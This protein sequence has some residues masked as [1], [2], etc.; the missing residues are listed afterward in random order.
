MNYRTKPLIHYLDNAAAAQPTPGGGSVA[1]VAGALAS[2][3]ASMAAGFTKGKE[4]FKD[5]QP[6]IE[7]ALGRLA[8]TRNRLLGLADEDMVA[9]ESVM[10]AYRMP[11]GTDEEKSARAEAV[12]QA[13][14]RSLGL[15]ESVLAACRDILVISLRLAGIANPNLISDVGVA[16]ELA[17][18]AAR[19]AFL[20]VEVNL[21]GY[22][23]EA[24]KAAV[25]K[26]VEETTAQVEQ[27]AGDIR[28]AVLKALRK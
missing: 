5:V 6:E 25:R 28:S 2:T 3:M 17:A 21:A 27:L 9:Y 14:K 23:D 24:D 10:A 4:K 16:G 7:E 26:R 22:K 12:R 20:N 18:G 11:K 13:T 8:E 15:V 19:A 1:A